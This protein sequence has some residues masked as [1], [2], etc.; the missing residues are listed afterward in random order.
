VPVGL[1]DDILFM[2]RRIWAGFFWRP[3]DLPVT[4]QYRKNL[5]F[6]VALGG[7]L[8][9]QLSSVSALRSRVTDPYQSCVA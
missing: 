8:E 7:L 6:L 9:A 2:A 3:S 4:L 1:I 5:V